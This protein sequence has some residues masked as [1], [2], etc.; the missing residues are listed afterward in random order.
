[1]RAGT[2]LVVSSGKILSAREKRRG[3]GAN[4]EIVPVPVRS[5]RGIPVDRILETRS[6]YWASWLGCLGRA[7]VVV[8]AGRS[9]FCI[10][11]ASIFSLSVDGLL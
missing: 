5:E 10:L 8:V 3:V 11:E 6:R 7:S 2:R 9:S 1:M 4:R